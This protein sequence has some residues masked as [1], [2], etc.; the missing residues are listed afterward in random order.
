MRTLLLLLAM[1]VVPAFASAGQALIPSPY[2][3]GVTGAQPLDPD[4]S[5]IGGPQSIMLDPYPQTTGRFSQG[6]PRISRRL[7][8]QRL[9]PSIYA[10]KYRVDRRPRR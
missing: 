1:V 3:S 5:I 4:P 2:P 7:R 8:H 9:V 6:N 10:R